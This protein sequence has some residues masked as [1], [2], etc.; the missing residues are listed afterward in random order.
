MQQQRYALVTGGSRGIGLEV[1]RKL[2]AKKKPVILT[3]RRLAAAQAAAETL[4]ER[5]GVDVQPFAL[6][7][8]DP[9]SIQQLTDTLRARFDQRIDLLVGGQDAGG[10]GVGVVW[11]RRLQ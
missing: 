7:A 1:C 10:G 9:A 8:S 5:S 11:R 2:V 6:E 3:A 4:S